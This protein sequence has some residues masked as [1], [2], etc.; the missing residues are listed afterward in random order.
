V[1]ARDAVLRGSHMIDLHTLSNLYIFVIL[2]FPSL[3]MPL[4]K[5]ALALLGRRP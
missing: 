1:F 2:V 5:I 3:G 4:G